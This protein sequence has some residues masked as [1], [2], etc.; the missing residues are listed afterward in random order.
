MHYAFRPLFF[1]LTSCF[2]YLSDQLTVSDPSYTTLLGLRRQLTHYTLV[3]PSL[4]I[5]TAAHDYLYLHSFKI[6]F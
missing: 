1:Y 3:P 4:I 5:T 6:A 2:A